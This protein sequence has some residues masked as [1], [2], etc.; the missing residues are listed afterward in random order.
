VILASTVR[1]FVWS[2][3]TDERY[4]DFVVAYTVGKRVFWRASHGTRLTPEGP[5]P[6]RKGD[7]VTRTGS[8]E[9]LQRY[10]SECGFKE[11][12]VLNVS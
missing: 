9:E 12:D 1:L 3:E 7:D 4:H 8:E 5:V 6:G 2:S 10:L 11:L